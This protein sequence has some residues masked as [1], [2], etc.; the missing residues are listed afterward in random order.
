MLTLKLR[1]CF[2][3]VM[4]FY[5]VIILYLLK[6]RA[7]ELKY[8]LLWILS[9][10]CLMIFLIRPNLLFNIAYLFGIETGINGFYIFCIAV[11]VMIIMSLTSIVSKQTNKIRILIQTIALME[12]RLREL[13]DKDEK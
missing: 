6:K 13:E 12:K 5:F 3:I 9:G 8:S 11:I 2:G 10:L 4:F 7:L 1:I